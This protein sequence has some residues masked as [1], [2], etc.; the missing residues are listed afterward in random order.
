VGLHPATRLSLELLGNPDAGGLARIAAAVGLVQNLAALLAL[1]TE[2]IQKGHMRLHA[3]RLAYQAGARGAE[4]RAVAERVSRSGRFRVEE[5]EA[6]LRRLRS[7][8]RGS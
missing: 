5:A 1:V 3:S 6:V 2:G 7:R 8:K 4:I